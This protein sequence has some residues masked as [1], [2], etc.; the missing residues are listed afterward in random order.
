MITCLMR[1]AEIVKKE[2]EGLENSGKQKINF[3]RMFAFGYYKLTE[4]TK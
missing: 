4:R 2:I 3:E 1:V